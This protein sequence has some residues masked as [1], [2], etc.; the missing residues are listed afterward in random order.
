[1]RCHITIDFCFN[2]GII[3]NIFLVF[4]SF[5]FGRQDFVGSLFKITG[6][7]FFCVIV[8]SH[9]TIN[10]GFDKGIVRN[11]FLVFLSFF[12]RRQDFVGV[13][14]KITCF[15]FSFFCSN[16]YRSRQNMRHRIRCNICTIIIHSPRF[17]YRFK[18]NIK[19]HC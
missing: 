6:L 17:I 8:R 16:R 9:I 5:F 1:M 2:K 10:L 4:L 14:F 7:E 12:F 11:I 18:R 13:F 3:R 15:Q 19:C